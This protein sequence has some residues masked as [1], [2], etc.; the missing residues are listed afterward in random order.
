MILRTAII[1]GL[2]L[3]AGAFGIGRTWLTSYT[4]LAETWF[5]KAIP[6][7]IDGLAMVP[8]PDNP[9]QSYTMT[10]ETYDMLKPLAIISR[11]YSQGD[12]RFDAVLIAGD[13]ADSF[14]DQRAC[15]NAQ[16]WQ[17]LDDQLVEIPTERYGKVKAIQ[18]KLKGSNGEPAT[19]L[20]TIRGPSGGFFNDFQAMWLDY[21]KKELATGSIHQGQFVRT[22]DLTGKASEERLAEFTGRYLDAALGGIDEELKGA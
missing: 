1:A 10:Q 6:L 14:H 21:M 22:I 9:L 12:E 4:P 11:I 16:G 2:C 13:N 17:I 7:Q 3:A 20:Y 15:F 19:A 18:L 8:G 5:E